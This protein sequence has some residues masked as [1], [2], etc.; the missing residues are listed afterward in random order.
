MTPQVISPH[1]LSATKQRAQQLIQSRQLDE[2]R[3]VLE[4]VR[5]SHDAD[6][7]ALLGIVYGMLGDN[8]AAAAALQIAVAA[9]PADAAVRNNLGC[10]QR[11]LGKLAEAETQFRESL[12]LKPGVV[13]TASNLSCVLIDLGKFAEAE[14]VLRKALVTAPNHP[15]VLN[16]LG[17]ALRQQ[18]RSDEALA[19]YGKA[20]QMNPNYPDALVNLGMSWLLNNG[21]RDAEVCLR[22]AL[23]IAPDHVGA[24]YYLGFSL[25]RRNATE[26]AAQCF[27]RIL[28]IQPGHANAAYFLSMMGMSEAPR[29]SPAGYV[30]ELFDGYADKFEDHLVGTLRYSA[31]DVMNRLVRETLGSDEIMLD[32][33]DLG[34]GTGLCATRF[35]DIARSLVGVD[36]S[37]RMLEKAQ[38]LGI[39]TD[40]VRA[41]VGSFLAE[42]DNASCDLALAGD[43]FV[44]IGELT[45]VF[46]ACA[47]V[48]RNGGLLSFSIE[49]SD[50][51]AAYTL[52]KSGRYAQRPDYIAGLAMTAGLRVSAVEDFTL[53]EEFGVGIPGQLYVLSKF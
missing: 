14:A 33:L 13:G 48:L 29:Q 50:D 3:R 44:Y 28:T 31:P 4:A 52:R 23:V 35:A 51:E 16:N 46:H 10:A 27:R 42:R 1:V 36:L 19:C 47:R 30:K 2:A 18:G 15:E 9:R 8:G 7:Q 38:K 24:L 6:V 25:Y 49:R 53:R 26:D 39:Y 5:E 43:V 34:C 40:L 45:E 22:K 12:R 11:A 41:D 37:E 17:T 32:I 21:A 20:V